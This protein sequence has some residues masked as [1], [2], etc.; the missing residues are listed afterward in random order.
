MA[1]EKNIIDL[2]AE[3]LD[4]DADTGSDEDNFQLAE[5]AE[6]VGEQPYIQS[7]YALLM[8]QPREKVY[9]PGKD[10]E[11]VQINGV[12]FWINPEVWVEVPK[13]VAEVLQNKRQMLRSYERNVSRMIKAMER[14]LRGPNAMPEYV[15]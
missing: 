1:E 6:P 5:F 8:A 12:S 7:D 11:F 10:P 2:L 15:R 4:D 9:I 13:P 3:G 14:P